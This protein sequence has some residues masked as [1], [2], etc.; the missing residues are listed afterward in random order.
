MMLY[1]DRSKPHRDTPYTPSFQ[2]PVSDEAVRF[3]FFCTVILTQT[4][5]EAESRISKIK[6]VEMARVVGTSY[7][8]NKVDECTASITTPSD[9][10]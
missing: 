8:G 2:N 5:G 10:Y 7:A 3:I 6:Y 1:Q 4:A 9:G